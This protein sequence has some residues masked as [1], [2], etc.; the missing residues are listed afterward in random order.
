MCF[1]TE[2]SPIVY[3]DPKGYN[4]NIPFQRKSA[5]EFKIKFKIENYQKEKS[6][7]KIQHSIFFTLLLKSGNNNIVKST[8]S[9]EK[10]KP[11]MAL[12]LSMLPSNLA[13]GLSS[14]IH[15]MRG[16]GLRSPRLLWV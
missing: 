10:R 1:K 3:S 13:L 9:W 14:L 8:W 2:V 6:S 11:H 5:S 12:I 16:L 7:F 15:K 4:G